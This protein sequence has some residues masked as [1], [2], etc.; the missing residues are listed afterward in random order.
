MAEQNEDGDEGKYDLEALQDK[1]Q[2]AKEIEQ[3]GFD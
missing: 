2:V 3:L 1:A